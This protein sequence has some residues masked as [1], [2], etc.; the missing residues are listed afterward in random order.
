MRWEAFEQSGDVLAATSKTDA[1]E[2]RAKGNG[3][4][5]VRNPDVCNEGSSRRGGKV[6]ADLK[7]TWKSCQLLVMN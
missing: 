6:W 7:A 3:M 5:Y 2:T 1:Y 4:S